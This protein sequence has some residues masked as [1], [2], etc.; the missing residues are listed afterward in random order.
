MNHRPLSS[1]DFDA[2]S[3]SCGLCCPAD[4]D[5]TRPEFAQDS[6]VNSLL[7]RYGVLPLSSR[8]A[9]FGEVDTDLDLLAAYNA[10]Q[11]ARE[12]FQRLPREL[13]EHA[14]DWETFARGLKEVDAEELRSEVDA[15]SAPAGGDLAEKP[16]G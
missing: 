7:A 11:R 16:K 6:D 8:P 15:S 12:A 2:E 9:T 10:L 13:R 4:E 3:A 5:K 1:I 14:G